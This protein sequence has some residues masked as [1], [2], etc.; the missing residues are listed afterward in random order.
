M[1]VTAA[2]IGARL[3]YCFG[4][5]WDHGDFDGGDVVLGQQFDKWTIE[6]T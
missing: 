2:Y 6:N 1:G 5:I 3:S 4:C